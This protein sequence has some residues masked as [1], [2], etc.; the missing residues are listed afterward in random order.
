VGWTTSALAVIPML[1]LVCVDASAQSQA[2]P[3]G[4]LRGLFG[5]GQRPNPARSSQQVSAWF[6]VGAG[7]DDSLDDSLESPDEPP[8]NYD[9]TAT[10]AF[11]YWVGRTTRSFET[12]ARFYRTTSQTIDSAFGGEVSATGDVGG[13]GRNGAV[14]NLRLA[15]ESARL[16]GAFGPGPA[17]S[18]PPVDAP[19]VT[20]VSPPSGVVENRWLTFGGGANV[21]HRWSPRQRTNVQYTQLVLRPRGGET[22]DSNQQGV[23]I[24]HDWSLGARAGLVAGYRFDQVRQSLVGLGSAPLRFQ[25]VEAGLRRDFRPSPVR[26]L[27]LSV[28]GGISQ[29]LTVAT[30]LQ[31]IEGDIE[32]RA[33]V[34]ATYTLTRQWLISGNVGTGVTALNGVSVDAFGNDFAGVN[35][36]GILAR[37]V[38]VALG[39]TWSRGTALGTGPGSF[40]A[41]NATATVQYGLR[42]GGIFAGVTRYTHELDRVLDPAEVIPPVIDR[43]SARVGF[44]VWLPLFGAF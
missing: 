44:T 41:S 9:Q 37:R 23:L 40:V 33:E 3:P 43:L 19:P 2:T 35:L 15:N 8:S 39:G 22:L 36:A 26:T 6:D 1:A 7:I 30:P 31:E 11:R 25:S 24:Q 32:P 34:R 17:L 5:G 27:S 28:M 29:I 42:Y 16:F 12:Q 13:G 10:A 21:F 38:T 18:S 14:V 20:D 4:T